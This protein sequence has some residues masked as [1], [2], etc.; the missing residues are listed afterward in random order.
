M[1]VYL[2]V[3]G[4]ILGGDRGKVLGVFRTSDG[5]K[6]VEVQWDRLGM[7]KRVNTERSAKTSDNHR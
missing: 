7:P 5:K 6:L 4:Q 2:S 1:V 3:D